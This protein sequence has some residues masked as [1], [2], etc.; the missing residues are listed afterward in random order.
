[1]IKR[2]NAGTEG[3]RTGEHGAGGVPEP[4]WRDRPLTARSLALSTL[5]GSDPPV[6]PVGALI[7][8][9]ELFAIP[10]GTMRTALSR[11]AA[12]GEA[13]ADGTGRYRLEGR[14]L[15]RR[16]AQEAGRRP[17]TRDWDGTWHW[18]V[19]HAESRTVAQRREFR[20][21]MADGRFGE[22][23]PEVWM[24]PA[25][26]P[27]PPTLGPEVLLG[28]GEVQ[29]QDPSVLAARLWD[30]AGWASDARRLVE[31]LEAA[32]PR[33][34]G[35]DDA[36]IP[37]NFLLSAAV[38]RHLRRDPLL[39][40]ALLP[41]DWPGPDLRQAYARFDDSFA[42]RLQ[43]FLRRHRHRLTTPAGDGNRR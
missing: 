29:G 16:A 23:R 31:D 26:L 5:L 42:R 6:L 25:N 43:A 28:T 14:H 24:R 33:L 39:P 3:E 30:L 22:L 27:A 41:P 1:M 4:P 13:S 34:A 32:V 11:M 9:G 12:A 19:V 36:E 17:P 8:L 21:Q 15:A 38:L 7:A 2:S 10:A 20:N 37:P 40:E 18:A 35:G